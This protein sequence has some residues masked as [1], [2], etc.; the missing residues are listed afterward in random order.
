VSLVVC[1]LHITWQKYLSPTSYL[2]SELIQGVAAMPEMIRTW[3]IASSDTLPELHFEIREPPLTGDNLGLKTWGTAFAIVKKLE[4]LGEKY[5]DHLL[6]FKSNKLNNMARTSE[7]SSV[8]V[9]ELGSGTGLVGIAAGAIWKVDVILTDLPEIKENLVFNINQNIDTVQSLGGSIQGEVLDWK[10]P[11]GLSKYSSME[12]EV[13]L[14]SS[15]TLNASLIFML[16]C[17]L[18]RPPL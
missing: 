3:D 16:D 6:N 8:R 11:N 18:C 17:H 14:Y 4:E 15:A 1:C 12:F 2:G 7:L 5:F 13:K 10:D 9:L